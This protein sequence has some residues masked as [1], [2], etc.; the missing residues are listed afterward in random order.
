MDFLWVSR[1]QWQQETSIY[2]L[3]NNSSNSCCGRR[4]E[5]KPKFIEEQT[6]RKNRVLLVLLLLQLNDVKMLVLNG[7]QTNVQ[8]FGVCVSCVNNVDHELLVKIE[9]ECVW[10]KTREVKKRWQRS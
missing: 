9:E 2:T 10:G 3:E 8:T 5:K 6:K 7:P 4:F 1:F